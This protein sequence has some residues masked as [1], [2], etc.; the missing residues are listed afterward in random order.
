MIWSGILI[1][2]ANPAYIPLPKGF[3][4]FFHINNRLAE[5]IAWHFTIMWCFA[6]N[7][8]IYLAYLLV[9]REWREIIPL[10]RSFKDAAL[11]VAHDLKIRRELPKQVGKINGAQRF[12]YTG[13]IVIGVMLILSGIAIHK[14]VQANLLTGLLGGYGFSRKIHF[15]SMIALIL[16]I[17]VHVAQ[18]ARA[19]WA[20]LQAMITGFEKAEDEN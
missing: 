5:G 20:N 19:G 10:K 11:V 12:A 16:F 9:T 3:V 4:S 7:G 14:P 17:F 6:L 18:V 1:Y 8:L 15:Y 13:A 2:W